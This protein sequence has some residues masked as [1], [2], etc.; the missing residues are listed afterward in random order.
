L[1]LTS[2][3]PA[4]LAFFELPILKI[5]AGLISRNEL[6]SEWK[7]NDFYIAKRCK[8]GV[9][10]Q[11]NELS[12]DEFNELFDEFE[13]D[14]RRNNYDKGRCKNCM[15]FWCVSRWEKKQKGDF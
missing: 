10:V 8:R 7:R 1:W 3:T 13:Y 9:N 4:Y 2:A 14:E 11:V 5:H 6:A 12:D 15:N